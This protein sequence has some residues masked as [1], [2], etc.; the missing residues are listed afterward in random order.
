[1]YASTWCS[2][3]SSGT[4]PPV[5]LAGQMFRVRSPPLHI[6]GNDPEYRGLLKCGR[7]LFSIWSPNLKKCPGHRLVVGYGTQT[8][9]GQSGQAASDRGKFQAGNH[10]GTA[11]RSSLRRSPPE[12]SGRAVRSRTLE[13]ACEKAEPRMVPHRRPAEGEA[14]PVPSRARMRCSSSRAGKSAGSVH[15]Y[16]FAGI[17]EDAGGLPSFQIGFI[18]APSPAISHTAR[19]THFQPG[20]STSTLRSSFPNS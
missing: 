15:I 12:T 16:S 17:G 3:I 10:P 7:S 19:R 2:M 4:V 14:P 18:N 20:A 8:E 6:G 13:A 9:F 5:G 11:A 1:M